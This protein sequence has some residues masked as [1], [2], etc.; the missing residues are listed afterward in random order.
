MKIGLALSGGGA[1]GL[2]HI[3]TIKALQ[4]LGV[5]PDILSGTSIGA[6]IATLYAEGYSPSEMIRIFT[7]LKAIDL[8]KPLPNSQGLFDMRQI[9]KLMQ[10]FY[11]TTY[12]EDLPLP[13]RIT[14]TDFE[15]GEGVVFETGEL[16]PILM[17]SSCVPVFFRPVLVNDRQF[18]DG[19]LLNNLPADLLSDCDF[20]IG[21]HCNPVE[22]LQETPPFRKVLERVFKV[23][24]GVNV[25]QRKTLCQAFIEPAQISRFSV[26]EFDQAEQLAK[27]GYEEALPI[28]E[29]ALKEYEPK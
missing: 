18:I 6:I 25:S 28:L 17:A 27:I 21:S 23:I 2:M 15:T 19:G 4:E 5:L 16:I 22:M 3:G 7:N 10:N 26:F 29:K 12:L 24:V 20:V 1:R 8:L 13:I 9:G 14:A 11:K